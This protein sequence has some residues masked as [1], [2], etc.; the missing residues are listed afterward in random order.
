MAQ[1]QSLYAT[2]VAVNNALWNVSEGQV[3]IHKIRFWDAVSPGT[4]ALQLFVNPM[5]DRGHVS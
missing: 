3:R 4:T 5:S 2:F 1:M